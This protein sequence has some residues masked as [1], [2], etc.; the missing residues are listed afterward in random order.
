MPFRRVES[1]LH[2]LIVSCRTLWISLVIILL[3]LSAVA[4][5]I[6]I[7]VSVIN[8]ECWRCHPSMQMQMMVMTLVVLIAIRCFILFFMSSTSP[9]TMITTVSVKNVVLM[10]SMMIDT[11]AHLVI[12]GIMM[13]CRSP[14]MAAFAL[15][16]CLA[17][18]CLLCR[19]LAFRSGSTTP[20][21]VDIFGF[22]GICPSILWVILDSASFGVGGSVGDT[23]STLAIF[24]L[25]V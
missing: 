14:L 25:Q 4:R 18:C 5:A 9:T 3:C 8:P 11:A 2:V 7:I 15:I 12:S 10:V 21:W 19:W 24:L 1:I 16:L 13:L 20:S 22:H 17:C 23:N 6:K